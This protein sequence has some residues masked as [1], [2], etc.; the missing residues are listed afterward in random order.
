MICND[1]IHE[2]D[3]FHL[4]RLI[5]GTTSFGKSSGKS[6]HLQKSIISE[7]ATFLQTGFLIKTLH[8]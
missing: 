5:V 4:L 8:S 1:L 3:T 2:K 6:L 7:E